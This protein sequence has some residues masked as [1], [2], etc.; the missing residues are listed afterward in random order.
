MR[1]ARIPIIGFAAYSGTGK[2]TLLTRLIPILKQHNLRIGLIKHSH[3]NFEIDKP[4]KDSY[5][6]R[7]AGATTVLL[8]SKYRRAIICEIDPPKEPTLDEQ[9]MALNQSVLDLILVEGFPKIELYRPI[10]K[11][12]LLY[13]Q[14]ANIIAVASDCELDLPPYLEQLDINDPTMVAEFILNWLRE[15]PLYD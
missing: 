6:L 13:P 4:E 11:K 12:P 5:R 3:H 1:H 2:T 7:A 15:N 9:L 8:A 14:D 10:L